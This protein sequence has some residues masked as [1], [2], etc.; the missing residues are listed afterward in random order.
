M[1]II[2]DP[3]GK[4]CLSSAGERKASL[5]MFVPFLFLVAGTA[6]DKLRLFLIYYILSQDIPEVRKLTNTIDNY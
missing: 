6:E 3:S 4:D 5:L 1:E 2:S